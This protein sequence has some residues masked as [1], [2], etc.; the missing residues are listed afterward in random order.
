LGEKNCPC[1]GITING[2]DKIKEISFSDVEKDAIVIERPEGMSEKVWDRMGR[3]YNMSKIV[4][5]QTCNLNNP[6]ERKIVDF[7]LKNNSGFINDIKEFLVELGI[8]PI[9]ENAN[10]FYNL[11]KKLLPNGNIIEIY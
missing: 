8:E 10:I 7:F 5:I 2:P 3:A 6:V 1:C 9:Q 4:S 11:D